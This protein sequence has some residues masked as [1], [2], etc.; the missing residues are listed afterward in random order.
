MRAALISPLYE[1]VPP[2]A[3]GGTERVIA[4]LAD[5]LVRLG[6]DVT[7]FAA[8]GSDT[9]ATLVAA[10]DAPLRFAM[11]RLEL[12]QIA[13]HLHLQMLAEVY[14]RAE[15]GEFDI[16]HAH[17]DIWTLPFAH[18]CAVPTVVTMHGR[19]DLD[20]VRTVL[21]MYPDTPLVSISDHQRRAVADL[22]LR[23]MATCPNGLDLS[24]YFA[25]PSTGPGDYLAFVGRITPE[26]RPDWAVEVAVRSG[27]P[28]RV[29]AKV[30]PLDVD[31]WHEQIEPLFEAHDVDFVGEIGE[32]DKPAFFAGAAA[33][34]FPIDW[35]EPF[36]LVMIESL[37]SGTPVIALRNGSVPEVLSDGQSGFIC[38]SLAEMV[39]AV[40]RLPELSPTACR[41]EADRFTAASMAEDYLNVY[42]DLIDERCPVAELPSRLFV[43]PSASTGS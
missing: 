31:Y 27:R 11:N 28:L 15:A 33:T 4:A 25:E 43:L 40:E 1:T 7:L 36:G 16:V 18:S 24:A 30:D 3:Y 8:G 2:I 29:A 10:S 14:A 6:H 22:S 19:L 41:A 32:A 42:A 20:V 39:D 13:P 34:L 17:T 38:D 26:K 37:A 35:P 5:Q 12:E 21:P 23:W 9:A